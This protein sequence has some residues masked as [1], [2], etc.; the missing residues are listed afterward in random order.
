MDEDTE[1]EKDIFKHDV[2]GV[3]NYHETPPSETN[4]FPPMIINLMPNLFTGNKNVA[5][6]MADNIKTKTAQRY[7]SIC[8]TSKSETIRL[9]YVAITRAKDQLILTTGGKKTTFRIFKCLGCDVAA[10]YNFEAN[11]TIDIFNNYHP[12]LYEERH[13]E[14]GEAIETRDNL[15][16]VLNSNPKA[17][18]ESRDMQPS[19]AVADKAVE[20][21]ELFSS[22]KRIAIKA[23]ANEFNKIGTCIHEIF[24]FIEKDK[25]VEKISS[26]I[27]S[28]SLEEKIPNPAEILEAWNNLEGFMTKTY[29]KGK[30]AHEVPFKHFDNGQ[31]FTGS[32]DF[33]W[34]TADGVVLVD[35]KSY[36]GSK[37]DVL[38]PANAHYAGI[39]SG[40][41]E[42]YE[43]ALKA[44]GKKVLAKLVYYHVL[45]VAVELD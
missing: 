30:T 39:Y 32:I 5:K 44:A 12:F 7:N 40:Q 17:E 35:F 25:N 24:A 28:S 31:I 11:N 43:R 33:I 41:F 14:D 1:D 27:K 15:K 36:P 8:A 34:E 21:K 3:Q 20:A 19:K 2:F 10:S 29:G 26:I 23:D 18:K 6:D 38:D 45:G 4:L 37:N 22:G 16:Y 42:C 13:L 9:L